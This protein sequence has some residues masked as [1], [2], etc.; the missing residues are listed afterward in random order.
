MG[1]R[2]QYVVVRTYSA[3]VHVGVLEYRDGKEVCLSKARRIWSWRERN[4][5]H[6][7]A[8]HGVGAGSRVSEPVE[9]IDLTEAIEVITCSDEG[10]AALEHATW[11]K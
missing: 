10:R 6:E 8:N 4:T 5:L 9:S 1:E 3:G 2:E 11:T 7:I